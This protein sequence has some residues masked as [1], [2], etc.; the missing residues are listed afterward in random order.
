MLV[1]FDEVAVGFEGFEAVSQVGHVDVGGWKG[2]DYCGRGLRDKCE[3][4]RLQES[5]C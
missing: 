5:G 3:G 1:A 4:E 2:H